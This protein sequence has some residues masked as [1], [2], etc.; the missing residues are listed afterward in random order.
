MQLRR[1]QFAGTSYMGLWNILVLQFW[2][3]QHH[4]DL[5][6]LAHVLCLPRGQETHA[7]ELDPCHESW[8]NRWLRKQS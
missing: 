7:K 2:Q 1:P 6:A 8:E 4:L 3:T 5:H